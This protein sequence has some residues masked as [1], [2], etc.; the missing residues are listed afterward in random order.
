MWRH[1]HILRTVFKNISSFLYD[2]QGALN[3]LDETDNLILQI[4]SDNFMKDGWRR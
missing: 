1:A 2:Y 3:I 4:L